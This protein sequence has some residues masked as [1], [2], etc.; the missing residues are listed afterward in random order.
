M[1]EYR[2]IYLSAF[3]RDIQNTVAWSQKQ[4]GVAAA[5]RYTALIRQ[6]LRDLLEEPM[7][8][9]TRSRSDLAPDA[10]VYP[11]LFSRDRV[12]GKRVKM[13]RHFILYRYRSEV[14]EFARLLQDSRDLERHVPSGLRT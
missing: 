14:V 5:E 11:L 2:A 9:G 1:A 6:A 13:P 12:A 7:R 10:F 8:P 3:R 4:F